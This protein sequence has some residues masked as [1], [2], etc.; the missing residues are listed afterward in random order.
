[1]PEA[2]QEQWFTAEVI[3]NGPF[4]GATGAQPEDLLSSFSP[5]SRYESDPVLVT[6]VP[7]EV[8]EVLWGVLEGPGGSR[9]I[10]L[11]SR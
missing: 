4:R 5:F 6:S 8:L 3:W 7:T 11:E 1:M 2:L 9:R 10:R